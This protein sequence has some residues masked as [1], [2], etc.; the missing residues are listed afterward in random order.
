MDMDDESDRYYNFHHSID[1]CLIFLQLALYG[2]SKPA[3]VPYLIVFYEFVSF[4]FGT[5]KRCCCCFVVAAA[6]VV[7]IIIIVV[8]FLSPSLTYYFPVHQDNIGDVL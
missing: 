2:Y 7:I 8:E 1:S 5:N 4:L 6:A 3:L